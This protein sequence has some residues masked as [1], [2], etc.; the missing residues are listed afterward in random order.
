MVDLLAIFCSNAMQWGQPQGVHL[1]P[2]AV[3]LIFTSETIVFSEHN[4]PA[5]TQDYYYNPSGIRHGLRSR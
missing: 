5:A 1:Q 4:L 2:L 3:L